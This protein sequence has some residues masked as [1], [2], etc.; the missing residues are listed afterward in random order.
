MEWRKTKWT[1]PLWD[2]SIKA[3]RRS[4]SRRK[5][6]SNCGH[7]KYGQVFLCVVFY[8]IFISCFCQTTPRDLGGSTAWRRRRWTKLPW[9]STTKEKLRN[10]SHR[11]VRRR[12]C[13]I[14]ISLLELPLTS[15]PLRS[16]SL[17]GPWADYSK[18]FGGKFGVEKEKVDQ[19]AVGYDYK[20]ET[21]K[22]QSQKGELY[23]TCVYSSTSNY[24]KNIYIIYY[25]LW[26]NKCLF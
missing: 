26:I 21:E 19:A 6:G 11:E 17:I 3:R 15:L 12:S 18:G 22:H 5:V 7:L 2:T 10:T 13:S 23:L 16:S 4:I 9:A 25:L 1:R 20:G 24:I 8:L 14:S